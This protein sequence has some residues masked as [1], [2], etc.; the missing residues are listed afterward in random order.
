MK[1]TWIDSPIITSIADLLPSP[2]Q[3]LKSDINAITNQDLIESIEP[4]NELAACYAQMAIK[5]LDITSIDHQY[6]PL[7]NACQTLASM[8]TEQV[9][10]H[11]TKLRLMNLFNRF[12]HLKPLLISLDN[13]G[14]CLKEV[15]SGQQSGIDVFLGN[16]ETEQTLQ[17]IKSIIS[18]NKTQTLFG[19]IG[20][21]L[22]QQFDQNTNESLSDRRLRIFWIAYGEH[23]DV[24][25]VLQLLLKLSNET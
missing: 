16:N 22:Q 9:T 6:H 10:L 14:L 5:G 7:F 19:A 11:A 12:S 25:P 2:E 24:L 8:L 17:Q 4:F 21:H 18:A 15:F 23:L 13:Y 20:Q 1:R 3:I